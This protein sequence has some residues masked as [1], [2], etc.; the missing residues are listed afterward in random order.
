[1]PLYGTILGPATLLFARHEI[2]QES[3][4][5]TAQI[6]RIASGLANE[7]VTDADIQSALWC[8]AGMPHRFTFRSRDIICA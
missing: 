7:I 2:L 6:L 4:D 5:R 8:V 3:F 1:M